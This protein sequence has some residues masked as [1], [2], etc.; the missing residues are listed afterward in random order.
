MATR[1]EQLRGLLGEKSLSRPIRYNNFGNTGSSGEFSWRPVLYYIGLLTFFIFLLLLFIHFAYKPIF[2]FSPGD[3]GIIPL[4]RTTDLQL[5]WKEPPIAD[6]SANLVNLLP[7]GITVALDIYIDVNFAFS[8]T[9]RT[10]LYR[11][12]QKV[13]PTNEAA[14]DYS[15]VYPGSNL[16]MFLEE[17][18]ND[19]VVMIFTQ[20]STNPIEFESA[21]TL[22]NVPVR[23][24]F[25]VIFVLLPNY[26]EVYM[27]GK[28]V[29]TKQLKSQPV[30]CTNT[31]YPT[32]DT[33]RPGVTV[34]NLQYWA[35]PL[36]ALEIANLATPLAGNPGS[37]SPPV[38]ASS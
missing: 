38:C 33:F 13:T 6:L 27:N 4:N 37:E 5:V 3:G 14:Q 7:C 21:P 31:F 23:Q 35:R 2:S 34:Q 30:N 28:L 32:P 8:K 26:L 11:G 17:D 15:T 1:I 19:L 18:T 24:F 16:L 22:Y 25:R 36:S 12:N 20:N 29:S 10:I 9:K